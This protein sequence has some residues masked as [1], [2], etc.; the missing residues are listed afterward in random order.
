MMLTKSKVMLLLLSSIGAM[1]VSHKHQK[2]SPT[3]VHT[4]GTVT[5]TSTQEIKSDPKIELKDDTKRD[6]PCVCPPP[7]SLGQ[8]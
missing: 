4:M 5:V 2:E 7:D 1:V 3:A 8:R 6:E